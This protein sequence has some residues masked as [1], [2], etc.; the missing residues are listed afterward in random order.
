V[1]PQEIKQKMDEILIEKPKK[2]KRGRRQMGFEKYV[3][4][5]YE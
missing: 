3:A 4:E 2:S 5:S 1:I